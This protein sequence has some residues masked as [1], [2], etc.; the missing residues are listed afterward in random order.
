MSRENNQQLALNKS[1]LNFRKL[2]VTRH[3]EYGFKMHY[4]NSVFNLLVRKKQFNELDF[5]SFVGGI[6]GLFAGFSALSFVELIY[7]F[8]V[9]VFIVN[10]R[11]VIT[12]IHPDVEHVK[13]N[14]KIL[15]MK[16]SVKSYLDQS[17]VHGLVH[18]FE[19]SKIGRYASYKHRDFNNYA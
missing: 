14:S 1:V 7:W 5:L 19:S 11:K 13:N 6:L 15:K 12:G 17:S 10:R 2:G 8:A 4:R 9:R 3:M 16:G 18:I